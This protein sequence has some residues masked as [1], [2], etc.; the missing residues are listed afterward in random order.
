MMIAVLCAEKLRN[1]PFS[2]DCFGRQVGGGC[3]SRE[4]QQDVHTSQ[5]VSLD[6][7]IGDMEILKSFSTI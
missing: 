6:L 5:G 2:S 4:F 1:I 7:L 3:G